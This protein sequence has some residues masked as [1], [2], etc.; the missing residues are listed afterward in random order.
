[1]DQALLKAL[2]KFAEFWREL[3]AERQS[4][5]LADKQRRVSA[6]SA[7]DLQEIARPQRRAVPQG[8]LL[9][10]RMHILSDVTRLPPAFFVA[11]F[12]VPVVG[13]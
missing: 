4:V 6:G 3:G 7:I 11:L 13:Q 1:M 10:R 8:A 2:E 9:S 12:A 5:R